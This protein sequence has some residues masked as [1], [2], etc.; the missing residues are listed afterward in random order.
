LQEDADFQNGLGTD[1]FGVNFSVANDYTDKTETKQFS[2]DFTI[3][4]NDWDRGFWLIGGQYFNED[5]DNWDSSLGW[6]NDPAAAAFLPC[7]TDEPT[8]DPGPP[9]VINFD[10]SCNYEQALAGGDPSKYIERQ[11]DSYSA[12]GMLSYDLTDKL[13]TA[14]EMR[15]VMDRIEV[16]TNTSIDRVSQ[17]LL[18]VPPDAGVFGPI[19]LPESD[20]QRTTDLNPRFTADYKF[21]DE[22]MVYASAAKG[23]KPGGYGTAQMARPQFARMGPETLWAYELGSKTS[24]FEQ[25]LLFNTAIF[26]N[27]Y[28]DRQVGITV[29]DPITQFPAAGIV[30][31]GKAETKGVE[32][33]LQWLASDYLTLGLGYA[34]TDADW[35][36]FDYD[37]IRPNGATDKDRAICQDPNG[38]CSGAEVAGIPENALTLSGNWTQPIGGTDMEWFT[39][40]NAAYTDKRAVYDR[41]DTAFVDSFWRVDAQIGLQTETWSALLYATNLFDDDTVAWGQ[42]YQD[43]KDGMYGGGSGGEPRDETVMAFVP[44]PRIVGVRGTYKFGK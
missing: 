39:S 23:T 42:G 4:S 12:Y 9:P 34:Y 40:A 3:E 7:G 24:W 19:D 14:V 29:T 31:A 37:A 5:V 20:S 30:N 13:T 17:Y 32:V 27:D 35:K 43:F 8:F 22:L 15:Y 6:Y 18:H 36:D 25:T 11:T 2:Q 28:K 1:V 26:Y 10:F 33:E 21:T 38:D 41:V 16:T 44:D